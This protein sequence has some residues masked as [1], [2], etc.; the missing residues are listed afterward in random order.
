VRGRSK[1]PNS[2]IAPDHAGICVNWQ[3]SFAQ[4]GDFR[5][6]QAPHAQVG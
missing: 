5:P 1:R 3:R 6:S 2:P 4:I